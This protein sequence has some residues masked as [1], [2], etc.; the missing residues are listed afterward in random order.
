MSLTKSFQSLFFALLSLPLQAGTA[1]APVES[2]V[3]GDVRDNALFLRET[4]KF[5]KSGASLDQTSGHVVPG[6]IV[7]RQINDRDKR[8]QNLLS[9]MTLREK[10]G[11]MTQLEI[12][13]VSNDNGQEI[14]IDDAKLQKA[15]AEYG[16][17][18]IL[19]VNA[20]ALP[21]SK[22]HEIVGQIQAAA[23]KTRLRIPVLY[24]IDSIHGANY[25]QGSTLFPQPLAMAATWNPALALRAAQITAAETRSAYIPWNFSPVLDVGRQPLWPRLFETY[26]EDVTLAK[27]MGIATVRGYEGT[28]VSSSQS[29]AACLKH[30]VGYSA[31][32]SGA[33]RSPAQIPEI[34]LRQYYLPTFRAAIEAGAHTIMVNS[35]EVN[36]IPGHA[37]KYLLTDVLRGELHFHGVVVSDWGDIE[38]LVTVHHVAAD[39]KEATRLAVMAG[40]DMS[41]VPSDY[42]FSE[43]LYQLVQERSVPMTRID[44]AVGRILELKLA[45]GLLDHPIPDLDTQTAIGGPESQAVSLQAAR[46]AITLLKNQG[47]LLPFQKNM[48]VLVTGPTADSLVALNNGWTYTWQGGKSGLYPKTYPSLRQA[49]ETKIGSGNML[50][51]PGAGIDKA[52][53]INQAI[54]AATQADAIVLALGENSYAEIPGNIDDLTLPEAQLQLADAMIATGKPVVLVL[55]EGRPRIISSIA[56]RIPAIVMAYNP[57]NQGGQAIADV[58]FGDA[59]PSGRLPITYPRHANALVTYDHQPFDMHDDPSGQ[60]QKFSPQFEFGS[61]LSYTTFAY[62][63]LT[64]SPTAITPDQN[65]MVSVNV[66]NTGQREGK[67]VI[68]LYLSELVASVAPPGK[69]LVR[70]AKIQLAPGESQRLT[71]TLEPEDLSFIGADLKPRIEPGDFELSVGG[72]QTR[73]TVAAGIA[74]NS[75]LSPKM[76]N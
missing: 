44:E 48:R 27:T 37:N 26:G 38:R 64:V 69:R 60:L 33:D 73:F 56:D 31:P 76:K 46:E 17:G 65:V 45:L 22:W 16:V 53:D 72:L 15:V 14:A 66:G 63:D 23:G 7:S 42:R 52:I 34:T 9:R 50:Y 4:M 28:D 6:Q 58:L 13:M 61:G 41:M 54:D 5:G 11:Q 25:I 62:S 40:V 8:V 32:T 2:A 3:P 57:S 21:L 75:K 59:N 70:F 19:N 24:G 49:V 36:G 55:I 51:V 68:Q 67:A 18:S 1:I 71:F 12:G 20:E 35:G 47:N 29:V 43:L 10:I 74:K 39:E 30:Y